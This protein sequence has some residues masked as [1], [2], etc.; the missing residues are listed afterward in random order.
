MVTTTAGYRASPIKRRRRTRAEIDDIKST[1]YETVLTERPM[2]VRQV[3]Y[4]LVSAGKIDKTEGEYNSTVVRL[5]SEMRL[6]GYLP[7]DWIADNTRWMRKP[8][9][10]SN[11]R[12]MLDIT[13]SAY[14]RALWNDQNDYVEI[15]L[16]KDA[17]S[18]VVY[19]VTSEW[20]VPLMVTRGYPSLTFLN[21]AAQSIAWEEKPAYLYYFGDMDPSG[22]DI[23]RVVEERL[24]EFA[25]DTEIFFKRVAVTDDQ[26]ARWNLPTRPTKKSDTRSKSFRGE[27]VELD[28]IPPDD[29]RSM[30][31]DCIVQ[32]VD[33]DAFEK[34]KIAEASEREFLDNWDT[35]LEDYGV[36]DD[37]AS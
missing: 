5:L 6:S 35:I 34:T 27:S 10:H 3:F 8:K 15:W 22:L 26:V 29:L 2:T 23:P 13:A 30:V 11:L 24:T 25:P 20:D 17:L 37:G 31:N 7:F 21:S 32:H 16:E 36:L 12:S 33:A 18:G 9:T 1:I 4:R 19:G 14:R 28:A